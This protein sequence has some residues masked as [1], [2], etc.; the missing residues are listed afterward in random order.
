MRAVSLIFLTIFLLC[1]ISSRLRAQVAVIAHKDVPADKIERA[2]L[3]DFYTFDVKQWQSGDPVIIKD[4][5]PKTES[6]TAFYDYLGKSASRMKSIWLKM[7]LSGEGEPPETVKSE[8]EM[9][10]KVASTP[11]ALGFVSKS[12]VTDNVKVLLT[13]PAEKQE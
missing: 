13:I 10:K 9:V 11:G 7:L 4:L 5:K 3:L 6:K 12:K 2:Q 8:E 1:L